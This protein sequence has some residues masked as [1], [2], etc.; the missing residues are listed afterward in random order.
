MSFALL[1][2][3]QVVAI[4][5]AVLNPGELPGL[6]RDKSID[7]AV[8]RVENRIAYGMFEDVFDVAAA[9]AE[10]ISQGHCFNDGNKRTAF[11]TMHL[12][13]VLNGYAIP[14]DEDD[15]GPRIIDLAQGRSAA[16]DMAAWLREVAEA[17]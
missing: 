9:Y 17:R 2:A 15:V 8:A 12:C 5:D 4:H 3:D 7:A 11:S 10:A 1:S 13:L 6:A 14:L 16:E